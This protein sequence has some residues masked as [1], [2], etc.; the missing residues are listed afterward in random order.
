MSLNSCAD[1]LRAYDPDRFGAAMAAAPVARPRL[2]ALYALNLELAR[3]PFQTAEPALAEIRLQWWAERLAEMGQGTAPPQH[4]V[5]GA[6][7]DSWGRDAVTLIPLAEARRRDCARQPFATTA[8]VTTYIDATAG[9][10]MQAAG[11]A[12]N[13]PPNS[14]PVIAA[15]A[16]GT[17]LTAWLR[18]LP[19]LNGLG[20]GIADHK[21]PPELARI[22]TNALAQARQSRRAVP[23]SVAPALFAPAGTRSLL[24]AMRAGQTASPP[25]PFQRRSA[26]ARLALTGRW[27]L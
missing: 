25:S 22:A 17:G 4:D 13:A 15:Q 23:R 12:L 14:Q 2:I 20:L 7:W 16:R 11:S 24:M 5:L 27:W 19:Q 3:A 9:T 10:L 18:A 8:E 21:A 26:L 1:M 6:L